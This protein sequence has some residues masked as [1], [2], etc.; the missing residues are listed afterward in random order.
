[1]WSPLTVQY[2]KQCLFWGLV[3]SNTG[4]YEDHLT[5]FFYSD[6]SIDNTRTTFFFNPNTVTLK[7]KLNILDHFVHLCEFVMLNPSSRVAKTWKH[8]SSAYGPFRFLG[9]FLTKTNAILFQI[10][11][12][13]IAKKGKKQTIN[14]QITYRLSNVTEEYLRGHSEWVTGR[15][16]HK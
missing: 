16:L 9:K 11:Q 4:A 2:R 8:T 6:K 14:G 3:W 13:C 15:S 10:A 1:M 12:F 7:K 5:T